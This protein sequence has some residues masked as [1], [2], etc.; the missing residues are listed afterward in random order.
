MEI[1]IEIRGGII[2]VYKTEVTGGVAILQFDAP[3]TQIGAN[4]CGNHEVINAF[5]AAARP[6]DFA[7]GRIRASRG[8]KI[9]NARPC[10]ISRHFEPTLEGSLA[11]SAFVGAVQG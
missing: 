7:A 6:C 5:A 8:P 1:L 10:M 2:V 11:R 9:E 4:F 3:M